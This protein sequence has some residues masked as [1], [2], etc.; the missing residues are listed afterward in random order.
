MLVDMG[1][2]RTGFSCS[3]CPN[4][5]HLI[6]SGAS[7]SKLQC[8]KPT[9]GG[10]ML[11][12]CSTGSAHVPCPL[13]FI[14]P[15]LAG[16]SQSNTCRHGSADPT[17]HQVLVHT[18]E[19]AGGWPAEGSA[20]GG[21]L[22]LWKVPLRAPLRSALLPVGGCR[23]AYPLPVAPCRGC[24]NLDRKEILSPTVPSV[25]YCVCPCIFSVE[26]EGRGLLWLSRTCPA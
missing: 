15:T 9:W 4:Y 10:N 1:A 25:G 22:A 17:S 2:C 26:I 16:I 6:I 12:R 23:A 13:N 24:C 8:C 11:Q 14:L 5:A 3:T 7:S 20:S 19:L 18:G 21:R